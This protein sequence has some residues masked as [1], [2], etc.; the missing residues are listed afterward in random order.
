[1]IGQDQAPQQT[2]DEVAEWLAEHPRIKTIALPK[3]T[4][5]E[6]PKEA[7]WKDLKEEV[8]QHKWHENMADLRT[9]IDKYYQA[10]KKHAVNFLA[11]FGY[12]WLGGR[13][14]PLPEPA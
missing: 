5:E 1:M 2:S 9:K 14:C 8:S 12:Q 10:G 4:P 3:Y 11:Q 13:I 6:N 7:T